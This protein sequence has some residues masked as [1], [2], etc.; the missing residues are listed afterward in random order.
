MTEEPRVQEPPVWDITDLEMV[1]ILRGD[2]VV[3]KVPTAYFQV[4]NIPS[5]S[6]VHDHDMG[7][8]EMIGSD[9]MRVLGFKPTELLEQSELVEKIINEVYSRLS[10]VEIEAWFYFPRT[11][12]FNIE[13]Y[14]TIG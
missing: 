8:R 9:G 6:W 2:Q 7:L 11:G 12:T 10:E 14:G 13:G 5:Q 4:R 3:G 1:D